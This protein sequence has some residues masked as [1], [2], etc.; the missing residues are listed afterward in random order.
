MNLGEEPNLNTTEFHV[1][2]R[3]ETDPD[4]PVAKSVRQLA[5]TS[6]R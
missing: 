3:D 5:D 4:S 6:L 2:M 1:V